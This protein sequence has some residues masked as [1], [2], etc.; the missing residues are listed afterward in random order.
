MICITTRDPKLSFKRLKSLKTPEA[1]HRAEALNT[2]I[3][4]LLDTSALRAMNL[5]DAPTDASII[6]STMVLRKKPDNYKAHL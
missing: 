4:L 2:E 1:H 3:K 6:N 5:A